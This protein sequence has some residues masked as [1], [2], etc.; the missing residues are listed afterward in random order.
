MSHLVAGRHEATLISD[1]MRSGDYFSAAAEAY[2]AFRPSY[3][4]D[5][6]R[7]VASAAPGRD[8]AWDCAT[9]NGQAAV[10]LAQ[11]FRRVVATDGSA[12][13]LEHARP[14]A[15]VEYRI[16]PEAAS[17][18][19]PASTDLVTVAQALH[20]LDLDAFY[21]EVHRVLKPRGVL[22]AWCYAR[23]RVAPEIDRVIGWFYEERVGRYWPPQRLHTETGYR[24][25]PFPFDEL[26]TGTWHMTAPLTRGELVG[27]FGTWSAV[28]VA[29]QTEHTDPIRDLEPR[30]AR[31][32]PSASERRSV[33][34]P[35]TL[36]IGRSRRSL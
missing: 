9:G 16:A 33:T 8:L 11:W 20:W 21:P 3:P 28:A 24:D 34:W 23:C 27:Y 35:L 36:R 32:W 18:L 1:G 4:E 6:I 12:A 5:L 13:Q 22:A 25:V 7:F 15:R 30:L 14:A 31:V 17:G 19:A 2:A 29:R 10:P 26:P